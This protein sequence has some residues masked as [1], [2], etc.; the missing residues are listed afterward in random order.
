MN[1]S[2]CQRVNATLKFE[3]IPGK[4][5]FSEKSVKIARRI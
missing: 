2:S 1:M 4:F 3:E 5:I